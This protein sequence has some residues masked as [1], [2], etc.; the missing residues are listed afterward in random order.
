MS[1]FKSTVTVGGYTLLSRIVG[2]IRDIF[3]AAAL[4][5]SP[6]ADAF[7]VAFRL[8]N[9]FRALS[10]E[11]AFNSAF[12]PIYS[13]KLATDGKE[14]AT[15]FASHALSFM[16]VVLVIFS[17]IMMIFMPYVTRLLA[18]G[19]SDNPEQFE[20]AVYFSRIVF[21]YLLLI[22]MVSLY[23]GVLNSMGRFAPAAAATIWLNVVMILSIE[24]LAR[25]TQTPAH[26]LSWGVLIAGVV[27]L[28]WM[29]YA[30]YQSDIILKLEKPTMEEDLKKML[31]RMV[32][33]LIGGGI[34]QINLCVN[35]LL[36]TTMA[37]AVS[38]LYYADRMVQFPLALTG[39]AMGTVLL[40]TLSRQIKQ[41]LIDE[42]IKTTNRAMEMVLLFTIPASAAFMV[43]AVP[44]I[45]VM[46][47]RGAFDHTATI[48]TAKGLIAYSFGLPAF[49]LIKIF[50][51]GFFASG[52]TKTPV[53]IAMLCLVVNV[54][55]SLSLIGY[56]G[57]VG[58]AIA[59][60]VSSWLNTILLC[61]ILV[62]RGMYKFE[63]GLIKRM[64]NIIFSS[65][66]MAGALMLIEF[67]AADYMHQGF[68]EK[69]MVI[70]VMII[71]GV[72]VFFITTA[73]T[74][75]YKPRDLKRM[76]RG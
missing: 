49:V 56:I 21:P 34:T 48:E 58:L 6:L 28:L 7:F 61:T 70:T 74:G 26:A 65:A 71:S 38:Y 50:T 62:K 63:E 8:P 60:G 31:K 3:I 16:F 69:L 46:F 27:Q 32:P 33:G 64:M 15:I 1:L 55:V 35:T 40:P 51:P 20:V 11:G 12:V 76:I 68:V 19:F 66:V 9:F 73:V 17:I 44:L 36:A 75:G 18:P 47:E 42:S 23:G 10:A 67:L 29:M 22:S 45:G 2:Y 5:A 24:Y 52:D 30:A 41:N 57:Y 39:T 37:G 53:K 4:G 13:G 59:T 54:T 14:K 25:F 72:A 43:M